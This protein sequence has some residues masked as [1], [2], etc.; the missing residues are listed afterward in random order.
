MGSYKMFFCFKR[1]F[2]HNEVE[3]PPDVKYAFSTFTNGWGQM[4][5][6]QLLRFM[7][8][9]QGDTRST[10]SDAQAVVDNIRHHRHLAS[11]TRPL[12]TLDDFH[13]FLFS[14]LLNAP[15]ISQVH[16]DM[17]APLSHYYIYTGHN[18]YLTGNQLSSDASDVPIIKA[19]TEG[20]RVIE[21]DIWPNSAKDDI[22]V[23][24]GRTL[25]APV[26]LIKCLRSI[27]E[28]AF[29][30][31]PYPV[32]ITLEDHLTP[33]LQAKVAEMVTQTFGEMLFYP[34]EECL[35]EFL[36]PEE[37]KYR[38]LIST[39]PPKE[40]LESK[41]F[42][43]SRSQRERD[44]SDDEE[45]GKEVPYLQ[46]EA[47]DKRENDIDEQDQY[48]SDVDDSDYKLPQNAAPQYEH[49][50]AIRA[51]KPKGGL[52]N[53]LKVEAGKIKRLSLSE[54]ALE[55]AAAS[56]GTDLVRFTQKNMLRIYPKGT[57][58][59]SSNYNP[60]IGW[61]HG[62]QMVAFNMQGYGRSL[63]LMH[64]FF[65]ANG[66][67]GYVKKPDFLMEVGESSEVF[68]PVEN[69][70]VKKTLKVRI[71]MGDG[72]RLDFKQTHFDTY[73][74]PDFYTRVGI[75]GVPA[76]A[77]MAQT[78]IVEDDWAPVWNEEFIFPLTVPELALLRIEVHEHDMSQKDDFAG[79]TC[80]PVSELR[81][82]IRAVPL[83]DR[84][85][86]MFKSVKLLMRFEFV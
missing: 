29:V 10:I 31:S 82:G 79:Q 1:S 54:Q 75:A 50:I 74:P 28:H 47:S 71:Y 85:G 63:W 57:R 12:L 18:S 8:G 84:K 11:F 67:C 70:Q 83:F 24:H 5:P 26:A 3:P 15:F 66:G 62:A 64:G 14:P 51:G 37:L 86:K 13:H 58:V 6:E 4:S 45:W 53:S 69:L 23:L 72:W 61:T 21:L 30:A 41:T 32:I 2:R 49:I 34:P 16:Q 17:T 68:N 27:K 20:V 73:S 48:E 77:V 19:L 22:D 39:K 9:Y 55:K 60:L 42:K 81:L 59:N 7:I 56:H 36:S 33:D 38:I 35:E 44:S 46:P 43:G 76:D 25:T 78:S 65:R 40:Y 52:Q 80:L